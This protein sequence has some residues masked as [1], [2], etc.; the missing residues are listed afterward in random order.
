MNDKKAFLKTFFPESVEDIQL[1]TLDLDT[2]NQILS[3]L[4]TE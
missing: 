3:V 2:A 1:T 4:Q